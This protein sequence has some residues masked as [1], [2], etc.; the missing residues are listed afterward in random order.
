MNL[1]PRT[2][3]IR[4]SLHRHNH[5]M[6]AE[7]DPVLYLALGS[8][9]VAVAGMNKIAAAVAVLLYIGGMFV[10]RRLAKADPMMCRV[11]WRHSLQQLY[12][13]AKSSIWS[14]GSQDW[15]KS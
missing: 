5:V 1:A 15:R 12:Y 2:A 6:G 9:M 13:P 3:P 4:Q 14:L 7:R 10:L 8:F 11:W